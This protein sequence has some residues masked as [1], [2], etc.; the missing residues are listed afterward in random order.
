MTRGRIATGAVALA[1][2]L[3]ACSDSVAPEPLL[4]IQIQGRLERGIT[5]QLEL[6]RNGTAVG[7]A[8]VEWTFDPSASVDVLPGDQVVLQEAGPLQIEAS[9]EGR[10]VTRAVE[11]AIPPEIVFDM[12]RDANRDI[13]AMALD[14]RDLA[15]L[16]TDPLEDLDPT[17]TEDRIAFVSYRDGN[18]NLFAMERATE[19]VTSV[20][21]APEGEFNPVYT[22]DGNALAFIKIEEGLPRLTI[23]SPTDGVPR[24]P[25]PDDQLSGGIESHPNWTSSG[26]TLAFVSTV[27]G[28]AD[29]YELDLQTTEV[30][31]LVSS[32][33]GDFEPAWSPDDGRLAFASDRTGDVE[34]YVLEVSTSE[35]TRLT[36]RE[37]SDGQP[38]WLPDGR[39][40]FTSWVAGIPELR[41]LDPEEP[42]DVHAIPTGGDGS[43]NPVH[44]P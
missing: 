13:Y 36:H 39:I 31:S 41:W 34:L 35:V 40:V 18:A 17:A 2:L 10:T 20:T 43:R 25:V 28:T 29:I 15:R 21:T 5:A 33:S 30:M 16:T 6:L 1:A 12:V 27:G 37:G 44:L 23:L 22:D 19:E 42:S 26:Q 7:P 8:E 9:F 32:D 14:G 4:E 24:R 11:V 38:A 3:V